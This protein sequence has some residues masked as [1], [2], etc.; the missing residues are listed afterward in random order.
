MSRPW[1]PLYVGDYLRDTR[2]LTLEQH[3]AYLLLMMHYWSRGSLPTDPTIL[4]RIV[5]LH[6]VDGEN[7]W[8]SICRAIAPFFDDGWQHKRLDEDIARIE[9]IKHK[10]RV[11]GGKGGRQGRGK[12]NSQRMDNGPDQAIAKQ[13]GGYLIKKERILPSSS[14][15][16]R[17]AREEPAHPPQGGG[18]EK[19]PVTSQLEQVL[20]AKRWVEE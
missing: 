11:A 9:I 2:H 13:K 7:R 1:M 18:R 19:I 17:P 12:A 15:E 5:G 6:G 20:K 8:R 4:K 3:G 14:S 16:S 10:R